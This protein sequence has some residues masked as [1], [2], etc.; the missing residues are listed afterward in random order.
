[1]DFIFN[2]MD[3]DFNFND[4]F[5]ILALEMHLMLGLHRS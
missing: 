5:Q 1:V 2:Y 3:V 4:I